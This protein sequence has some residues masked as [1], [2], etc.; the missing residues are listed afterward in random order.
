VLTTSPLEDG[1]RTQMLNNGHSTALTRPSDPTT[2]RTMPL[3]SNPTEDQATLEQLQP[4]TQDGGK[5]SSLK[6]HSLSMREERSSMFQVMLMLR[7][8]TLSSGPN[9]EA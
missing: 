2:G 4:S 5:C 1:E 9:Q 7:T 6:V 3:K 8:E